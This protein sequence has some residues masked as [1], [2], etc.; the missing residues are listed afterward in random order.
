MPRQPLESLDLRARRLLKALVAQ[1][2]VDGQPVGSRTLSKSAGVDL[3]PATIRNVL[4]DLEDSGLLIAPHTSAGR[5]PTAQGYRLF[6]DSLLK[7][8]P[9]EMAEIE[10]LRDEMP[11]SGTTQE[12][13]NKVGSLL[14]DTTQFVGVVSVPT[15][16]HFGFRQIEFV[17]IGASRVLV[18]IVFND[19]EVQNRIIET[20]R[21]VS[22]SEL[23]TASNYLTA[24]FAGLPLREV[25]AR[26]VA[27]LNQAR[28]SMDQM[29]ARAIQFAESAFAHS[30]PDVL[31]AG[32]NKLMGCHEVSDI[33]KLRVLFDAFATKQQILGLLERS[34][35][36]DGVNVFIGEESGYAPLGEFSVVTAPYAQGGKV[37][38]VLGVIGPTRMAYDRVIPVV[39]A[40]ARL[41]SQVLSEQERA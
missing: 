5:V 34:L 14:S 30:A 18:V 33:D 24:Q 22:R 2:I 39:A 38:G 23:D 6:V 32:Q 1:Y 21:P 37:L 19:G 41:L 4:A 16:E 17:P 3:S 8:E 29:M 20:D 13:L 7:V 25:R 27:E 35:R 11:G 28:Q 31:V 36:A 15:R 10:R 40:S 9:L 12:L 26:L